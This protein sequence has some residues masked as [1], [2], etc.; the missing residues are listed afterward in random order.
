MKKQVGK[1][2]VLHRETLRRL[3]ESQLSKIAAGIGPSDLPEDSCYQTCWC[4][5]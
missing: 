3:T 2:L 5:T 1:R 4:D